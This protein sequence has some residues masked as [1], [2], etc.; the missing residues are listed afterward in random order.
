M[1][2]LTMTDEE[3]D[4][5]WLELCQEPPEPPIETLAVNDNGEHVQLTRRPWRSRRNFAYAYADR[6]FMMIFLP[7]K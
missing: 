5:L 7:A 1:R 4:A 6:W 2:P 3:A